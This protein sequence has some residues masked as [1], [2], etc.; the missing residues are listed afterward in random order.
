MRAL[1]CREFGGP[2]S[3]RVEEV[4]P[5]RPGPDQ[6]RIRV[7][8]AGVNFPDFLITSGK[9]QVKPPFPFS[10]GLECA[11]EVIELG[12]GVTHV[13]P[14]ARV[15]ATTRHGGC[16]AEE[17]V[18]EAGRVVAIPASMDFVK[19]AAFPI[20][21]GTS[22]YALTDRGKLQ[23]GET[24]L[25]T[26][27]AGGVG[28]TAVEIGKKLGARVIAAARGAD[29]LAIAREKGADE[30][31]D[32]TKESLK[33]RAKALTG[34]KGVDVLY[35]PVGGDL[36]DDCV[37]VMAR[38]GR[39]LVIG[40]AAGIP[41]VAT[42]L[43]LVKSFS[44]VGVTFG[45]QTEMDPWSTHRSLTQ[46][47]EWREKDGGFD[48]YVSDTYPLENAAVAIRRIAERGVTGKLVITM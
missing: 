27:A 38:E 20:T 26:G 12:E 4:E 11:G 6:V 21:F 29:R 16:F 25:V 32:Y 39:L 41:K 48:P 5:K 9:Y 1:L 37:R 43:I 18:V 40:F 15:M 13:A 3:L 17:L 42:N 14:G 33:E 7:K 30:V 46:L 36:F 2:E 19:A 31:I 45:A 24:L 35:D 23:P 22:H 34:G 47:L 28:L 8:A 10:P 44:L